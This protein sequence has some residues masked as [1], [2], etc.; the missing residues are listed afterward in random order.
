MRISVGPAPSHWGEVKLRAFYKELTDCPV[1]DVYVGETGCPERSCFSHRLVDDICEQLTR[2]GK[3]VYASSFVLVN[4]DKHHR[5][6]R[7]LAQ[8][9]GRIEAN[10]PA[11]LRLAQQYPTVGGMFLNICNSAAARVAAKTMIERIVL[12]CELALESIALI[13][14][15]FDVATEIVVHGHVP[16]A[17][18]ITCPTARCFGREQRNCGKVCQQRPHGI[19]LK[20]GDQPMFRIEGPRT[21]SATTYCLVEH[22]MELAEAG[23]ETVR[24]LPQWDQTPRIVHIYRNVLDHRKS[25]G[26]ARVELEV[27]SSEGLCNGWFFNRA[28]WLY[29]S[30]N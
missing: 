1:D 11:F 17:M 15:H 5:I 10:S 27:I 4:N 6:F 13:T 8:C 18:S 23:V 28:G 19:V 14:K 2:A 9:V 12:P 22:L 16:I 29:E 7:D 25:P 30:P 24:I 21:L 26:Q 20:A 3:I